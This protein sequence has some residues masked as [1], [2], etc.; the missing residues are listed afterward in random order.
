MVD[1]FDA[2][3]EIENL[4]AALDFA[5]DGL[6]DGGFVVG[7]DVGLDGLAF[8]GG[9]FDGGEVA[10]AGEAHVEGTGYGGGGHGDDVDIA[11]EPFELFFGGDAEALL[12]VDYEQS[13]VFEL[14]ILGEDSVGADEDVD[15]AAMGASEG[16][17]LLF[18]GA[19]AADHVDG[20][21]EGGHAF[22]EGV[23]VLLGKDGSGYEEGDLL[24]V[25]NGFEGAAHG[26]FGFAEADIAAE[27]LIHG[28]G[29][30]H[31]GFELVGGGELVSG[32]GVG[33]GG[34][35]FGLLGGVGG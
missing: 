20:D 34:F 25:L 8:L 5:L 16:F 7:D 13:E 22:D 12:F 18:A 31:G 26:N 4:S 9:G 29:F 24:A 1:G 28:L 30:F 17:V 33:E 11:A 19:E 27:E 10:D 15:F 3:V 23:V 35:E 21:G 32:F 6:D 2:V 14:D